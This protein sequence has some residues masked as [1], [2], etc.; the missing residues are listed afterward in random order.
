MCRIKEGLSEIQK[1]VIFALADN[2]MRATEV[3]R[4]LDVH[5]NTVLYHIKEINSKTGLNPLDFHD[6]CK[7]I[8][9]YKED[10]E[11]G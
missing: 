1:N 5:R 10:K 8:E 2:G 4:A 9:I 11:N 6:L 7:L 3:A